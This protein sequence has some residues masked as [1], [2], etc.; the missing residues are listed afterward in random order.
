MLLVAGGGHVVRSAADAAGPVRLVDGAAPAWSAD[1]L[2]IAFTSDRGGTPQLYVANADGGAVRRLTF[3]E[4]LVV[5][6][7]SWSPDSTHLVFAATGRRGS[8]LYVVDVAGGLPQR[9]ATGA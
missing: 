3:D 1:G 5:S 8:R 4:D 7:A 2:R 9:V 6:S